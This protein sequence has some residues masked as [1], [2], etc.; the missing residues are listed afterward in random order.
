MSYKRTLRRKSPKRK[1]ES[2]LIHARTRALERYGQELTDSDLAEI[3]KKIQARNGV[4]V[5]SQSHRVRVWNI[6]YKDETWKV[7]YDKF[8]KA[9]VTFLPKDPPNDSLGV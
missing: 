7:V 5:E 1:S 8:R 9:I 3:V 6:E 2:L 4:F